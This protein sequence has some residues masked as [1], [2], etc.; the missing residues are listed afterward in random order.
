MYTPVF[1]VLFNRISFKGIISTRVYEHGFDEQRDAGIH[2]VKVIFSKLFPL[3]Q[4][5]PLILPTVSWL[6]KKKTFR[7]MLLPLVLLAYNNCAIDRAG[8]SSN[9]NRVND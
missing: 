5:T 6:P 2:W 9:F 7:V 3:L 1:P 4:M 8:S